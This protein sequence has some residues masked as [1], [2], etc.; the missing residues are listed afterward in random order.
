MIK[1]ESEKRADAVMDELSGR[2]GFLDAEESRTYVK[3]LLNIAKRAIDARCGNL[4]VDDL[5]IIHSLEEKNE[6]KFV[7][8]LHE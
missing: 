6:A 2:I 1:T 4:L 5:E 3:S 8:W 7:E